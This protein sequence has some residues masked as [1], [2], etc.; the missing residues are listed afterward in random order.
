MTPLMRAHTDDYM[1]RQNGPNIT[2]TACVPAIT[3][4]IVAKELNLKKIE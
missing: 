1:F 3:L 4:Y 2:D